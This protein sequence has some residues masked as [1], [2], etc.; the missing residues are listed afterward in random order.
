M[1]QL[2]EECAWLAMVGV[3]VDKDQTIHCWL[4]RDGTK[5]FMKFPHVILAVYDGTSVML[6]RYRSNGEF[7][8]DTWA[9]TLE[10]AKHQA[11]FEYGSALGPWFRVPSEISDARRYAITFAQTK[12]EDSSSSP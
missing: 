8:G 9:A 5:H 4:D 2:N 6:Y 10:D 11:E 12:H 1:A 3:M 7:C